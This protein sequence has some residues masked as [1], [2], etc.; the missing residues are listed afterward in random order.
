MIYSFQNYEIY[1]N[2]YNKNKSTTLVFLHGWGVDSSEFASFLDL[3]YNLVFVD[4]VGFGASSKIKSNLKLFD[5]VKQ[6]KSLMEHLKI[7]DPI[8]IGHSFGGRVA[9]LYNKLFPSS[10]MVLVSSAG[11]KR[12]RTI[13]YYYQ[14]YSYK[15]KRLINK[16]IKNKFDLSKY[17]SSDYQK[18]NKIERRVFSNVVNLDLKKYLKKIKTNTLLL[19][20]VN[21][22]V[23]P[24]SDGVLM[25]K[26][27]E[28][29]KL[30]PFYKSQH[31]LYRSENQKFEMILKRFINDEIS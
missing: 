15:I 25:N 2:E 23:I 5:Y 6:L 7:T 27:I 9:I 29:S 13:R 4:F 16:I 18:L 17:G 30:I 31:F 1:Y 22:N 10:K 12:R 14:I 26:L 21:D 20:A 8:F 11:L 24:Y 19:F 3:D 28:K